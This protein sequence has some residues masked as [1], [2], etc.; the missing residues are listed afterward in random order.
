MDR[1][2]G[3]SPSPR[4][5]YSPRIARSHWKA[6]RP[7]CAMAAPRLMMPAERA[8]FLLGLLPLGLM[9]P[10]GGR[11]RSRSRDSASCVAAGDGFEGSGRLPPPG[12][13]LRQWCRAPLTPV[14]CRA[15][16]TCPTDD[17]VHTR[18]QVCTPT[19]PRAC[20]DRRRVGRVGDRKVS[21][22]TRP[23]PSFRLAS[24]TMWPIAVGVLSH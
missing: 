6:Q 7:R 3:L 4:S 17:F 13:P 19:L 22:D 2:D 16:R 11:C 18:C 10:P 23:G 8:I 21:R 15:P 5:S 14:A 24:M 9:T 20:A 12:L 1:G